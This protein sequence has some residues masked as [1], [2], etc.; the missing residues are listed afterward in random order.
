MEA[1]VI[2]CAQFQHFIGQSRLITE[3]N[4]PLRICVNA[5]KIA[6][7]KLRFWTES[8]FFIIANFT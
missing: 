5:A 2:L 8:K 3:E 4:G 1:I 7:N 6:L